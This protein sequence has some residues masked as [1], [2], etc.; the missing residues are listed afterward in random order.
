MSISS[1]SEK[2]SPGTVSSRRQTRSSQA[3]PPSVSVM[4]WKAENHVDLA[5]VVVA[6]E[7]FPQYVLDSRREPHA[8]G[9]RK[10]FPVVL[11][12]VPEHA[13]GQQLVA[14]QGQRAQA[15]VGECGR[16]DLSLQQ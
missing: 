13:L 3:M 9:G 11:L 14:F 8:L 4:S 15:G 6:R 1:V 10:K 16:R 7:P 5:L 2:V 12:E